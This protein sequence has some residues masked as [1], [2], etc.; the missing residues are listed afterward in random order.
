MRGDGVR[1]VTTSP[2]FPTNIVDA[3]SYPS[4]FLLRLLWDLLYQ[5]LFIYVLLAIITGIVIDAFSGLRDERE[6]AENDLKSTCF[7]CN[8]ERFRIDQNGSGF[9]KHIRQEHNPRWYLFFL[10]YIKSK[11]PSYL[12]GQEKFVYN[13]VWPAKGPL[14]FDWLPRERTFHLSGGD[15]GDDTLSKIESRMD[16]FEAKLAGCME[17]LKEIQESLQNENKD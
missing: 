17:I 1:D 7:I 13:Q 11:Q 12:T 4:Y 5:W 15:E 9:E 14:H 16:S 10:I 2:T 8:L 3:F 6:T